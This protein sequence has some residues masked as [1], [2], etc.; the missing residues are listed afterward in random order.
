MLVNSLARYFNVGHTRVRP[1]CE[2]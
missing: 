2:Q 1:A